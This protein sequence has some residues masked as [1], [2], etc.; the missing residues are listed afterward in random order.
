[1]CIN[2]CLIVGLHPNDANAWGAVGWHLEHGFWRVGL[3]NWWRRLWLVLVS[4]TV[5]ISCLR[6]MGAFET[7]G[8]CFHLRPVTH[9]FPFFSKTYTQEPFDSRTKSC[10]NPWKVTG[11]RYVFMSHFKLGTACFWRI[12][13][14]SYS[15]GLEHFCDG[16]HASFGLGEKAG[17]RDST[18]AIHLLEWQLCKIRV[19]GTLW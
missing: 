15:L 4:S 11:P 8:S 14:H 18:E 12:I 16:L 1:M 6:L 10:V 3:S 19:N 17:R 9:M 2:I 13:S 7:E 5:P